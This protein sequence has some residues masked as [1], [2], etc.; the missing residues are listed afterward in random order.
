MAR[1]RNSDVELEAVQ[2]FPDGVVV[3]LVALL[4]DVVVQLLVGLHGRLQ[5]SGIVAGVLP[6]DL[7]AARTDDG[8]L[9]EPLVLLD[10]DVQPLA[11]LEAG[12]GDVG[13][14]DDLQLALVLVAEVPIAAAA[15]PA[16]LEK[17][18]WEVWKVSVTKKVSFSS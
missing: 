17:D 18:S 1:S 8:A 9:V 2:E 16:E 15:E 5:T 6:A 10:A 4:L 12:Q 7:A 11:L 14:E 3:E 13:P